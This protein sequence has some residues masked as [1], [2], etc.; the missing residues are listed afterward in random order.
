MNNN[1]NQAIKGQLYIVSAPSGAGKTSLLTALVNVLPDVCLSISNTTRKQRVGEINGQHYHF[2]D[3]KQFQEKIDA[4]DF[5]E[6]AQ[7]FDYYYGT[8]LSALERQLS[9]GKDVILEIDWQGAQQ[10][11]Q[12]LPCYSLFILPPSLSTLEERLTKRKQDSKAI[13]QRRMRDARADMKHYNEF[14]YVLIN[15]VFE[16]ACA[17]L[18]SIFRANRFRLSVQENQHRELL[19]ELTQNPEQAFQ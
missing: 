17:Q 9:Q 4:G 5:L 1:Q 10:V 16:I 13:I 6:Y 11:R 8:S 7:V 3:D 19:L 2:I 12:Q 18:E 15:D 14:D